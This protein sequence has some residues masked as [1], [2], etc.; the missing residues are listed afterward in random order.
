MT[1]VERSSV[2]IVTYNHRKYIQQCLESVIDN[3]PYEVVLVDNGSDDT[4]EYVRKNFPSVMVIKPEKN[5]GYAAGN[6]MGVTYAT[7]EYVIIL[8][9]D[10]IVEKNWLNELV[11]PLRKNE[12][13]I[14]TPKILIYDGSKINTCGNINH[15]TGLTFTRGLGEQP[16]RYEKQVYIS[17][18]SGCC[19]A[20]RK[21][22][23]GELGGFDETFFIY[24]ED[25]DLSWRAHL[26]GFKI[27][28]VSSSIVKHDYT[29]KVPPEKI[30]FLERNRYVMLKKYISRKDSLLLL[31]SLLL[32]EV[33]T[34]G[35]AIKCGRKGIVFKIKAIRDGR[36]TKVIKVNGDKQNLFKSL[37]S[38]IPVEQL[39]L[40]KAEKAF[41]V[42]ANVI[43]KWNFKVVS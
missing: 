29:L 37:S 24:N 12:R 11:D 8:N 31:P 2:I 39:T 36:K 4:A 6:N 38:T 43:F 17:G 1:S 18:L 3:K 28:Y 19:F 13:L 22:D 16:D 5:L 33:L 20:M 35:Y 9:P 26:K 27:M 40:N 41:E 25:S 23:F 32:V 10:T 42:L 30:Y 34:F 15:F 21:K 14:T 7:G